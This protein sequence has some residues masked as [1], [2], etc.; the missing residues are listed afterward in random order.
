MR[1]GKNQRWEEEEDFSEPPIFS[2]HLDKENCLKCYFKCH[3]LT[4][5]PP[6]LLEKKSISIPSTTAHWHCF[7]L[8]PTTSPVSL[9]LLCTAKQSASTLH[10]HLLELQQTS[11]IGQ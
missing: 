5:Y 8:L 11:K 1:L 2:L 7:L 6:H 3:W 4:E 9:L 10:E